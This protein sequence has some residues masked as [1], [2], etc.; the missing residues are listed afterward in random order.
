LVSAFQKALAEYKKR[1]WKAALA[2]FQNIKG[3]DLAGLY[4]ERCV[5]FE[6]NP[7][8]LDWDGTFDLKMK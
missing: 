4:A 6:K 5:Q 7:P 2:L 1:E 3:D 8:P